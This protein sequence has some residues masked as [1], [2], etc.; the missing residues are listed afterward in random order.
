M[1]ESSNSATKKM[2]RK[3]VGASTIGAIIEWYDFF[4]YST[5]SAIIFPKLFFPSADPYISTLESFG[6]LAVGYV[7]RPVGAAIFGHFGDR[8]GRKNALV[9]TL[10]LMGLS[11]IVMGLLPTYSTLG[12]LAPLLLIIARI[13]QGIGVGGEWAGSILLSME[14]GGNKTSGFMASLP[15]AGVGAGQLVASVILGL[16]I[17]LSGSQFYVWGWRLPFLFSVILLVAGVVIRSKI[18]ETPHFQEVQASK[19]VSALPIFEVVKSYPKQVLLTI[20]LKMSE[21]APYVV[22]TVFMI[23]YSVEHFHIDKGFLVT[24]ITVASILMCFNI[25]LFGHVSDRIGMKRVYLIGVI[26]MLLWAFPYVALM[27][28][29]I[30]SVIFLVTVL[31]MFPHN[32]QGGAQPALIAQSFPVRLRYSGA[33]LGSQISAVISGGIAPIICTYLLHVF[34]TIYAVAGYIAFTA[35]VSLIATVLVKNY[36]QLKENPGTGTKESIEPSIQL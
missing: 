9:I 1:N 33:A 3:A 28:T 25:P 17:A 36:T 34:G 27:N 11:T 4:L 29:G 32:I 2:T 23:G 19:Q 8:I 12:F 7:A 6:S 30:P 31:S 15:N 10:W 24:A 35:V 5:A 18:D 14:W 20:F 16:F 22:F 21:H 13:F 26:L